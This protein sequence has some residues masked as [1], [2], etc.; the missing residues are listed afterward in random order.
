M[1]SQ[2]E[3][4]KHRDPEGLQMAADTEERA[5]KE[6]R[7]AQAR[8][9]KERKAKK[10]C[11]FTGAEPGERKPEN[12]SDLNLRMNGTVQVMAS[13]CEQLRGTLHVTEPGVLGLCS[14]MSS[15]RMLIHKLT[16]TYLPEPFSLLEQKT[17]L[18]LSQPCSVLLHC[19]EQP[20]TFRL[21]FPTPTHFLGTLEG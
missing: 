10:V 5:L 16:A 19:P 12:H 15:S 2:R 11:K 1:S 18:R 14:R 4:M 7:E 13:M 6:P 20:G 3:M 8:W 21:C 9:C 17:M